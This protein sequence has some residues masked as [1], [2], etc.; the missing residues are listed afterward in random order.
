MNIKTKLLLFFGVTLPC[1]A[2]SAVHVY[3]PDLSIDL[4]T[5]SFLILALLPWVFPLVKSLELPGGTKIEFRD[6]EKALSQ[7]IQPLDGVQPPPQIQANA[8]NEASFL[9]L[10]DPNLV[11]V[12]LRIEVE[13][14]VR[15]LAEN[16]GIPSSKASLSKLIGEL[17]KAGAIKQVEMGGLLD[18]V[19]LGNRAAHGEDVAESAAE[20][21]KEKGPQ[22]LAILDSKL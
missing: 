10:T 18:L 15:K 4:V 3:R 8:V 5:L 12:S 21:A 11:L 1:L 9:Q 16:Y 20:W 14:R 19:A 22:V 6:V 17:Q 13:R 2:I 7:F